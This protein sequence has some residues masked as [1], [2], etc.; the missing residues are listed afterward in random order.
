[1]AEQKFSSLPSYIG[2]IDLIPKITKVSL[3]SS[4]NNW[5]LVFSYGDE[6]CWVHG[7]EDKSSLKKLNAIGSIFN[8]KPVETKIK[9]MGSYNINDDYYLKNVD[10]RVV[11]IFEKWNNM[12][13]SRHPFGVQFVCDVP[14][15]DAIPLSSLKEQKISF[16]YDFKQEEY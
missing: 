6:Y 5:F 11:I 1:M 16:D 4:N 15:P 12:H 14:N 2:N 9:M 7:L 13:G 3:K 10:G 8:I